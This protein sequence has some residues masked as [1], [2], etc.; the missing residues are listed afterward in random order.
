MDSNSVFQLPI[1]IV[2]VLFTQ[3]LSFKDICT[4]DSSCCSINSRRLFSDVISSEEF[5]FWTMPQ[6]RIRTIESYALWLVKRKVRVG[7]F[8]ALPCVPM[9]TFNDVICRSGSSYLKELTL[10][11]FDRTRWDVFET[12]SRTC[13]KLMFLECNCSYLTTSITTV[14]QSCSELVDLTLAECTGFDNLSIASTTRLK[15]HTL[16]LAKSLLA[17][18]QLRLLVTVCPQ[19]KRLGLAKC[20]Q[21]T[22][23]GIATTAPLCKHLCVI[24]FSNQAQL[25]DAAVV[26]MAQQCSQ[27]TAV[28]ISH[29]PRL[30]DAA[31][32]SIAENCRKLKRLYM[33]HNR[34]FT[35]VALRGLSEHS[36]ETLHSLHISHCSGLHDTAIR[37]VVIA[38]AA[39]RTFTFGF[40]TAFSDHSGLVEI[41]HSCGHISN[42]LSLQYTVLTE[43][44]LLAIAE[45][46]VNLKYLDLSPCSGLTAV[47]LFAIAERCEHLVAI[48]LKDLGSGNM[49]ND[50]ARAFWQRLRPGL[51][52]T[53]DASHLAYSLFQS[54]DI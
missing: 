13:N 14:L 36:M 49:L 32:V 25:Q 2:C 16:S 42:K 20:S 53:F 3:W 4:F 1:N 54:G 26:A 10:V 7:Q 51:T 15:L 50:L 29:C 39:L 28:D 5:F 35:N 23:Q 24:D 17:D 37:S 30:T 18:E 9:S 6:M 46:C 44:A 12:V 21:L 19:L 48:A 45:S 22:T 33:H 31:V 41:L 40:D 8:V 47:G 38:L 34:N 43:S 11:D 27:L 52:I